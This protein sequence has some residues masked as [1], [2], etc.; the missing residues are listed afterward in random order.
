M[1]PPGHQGAMGESRAGKQQDQVCF[2][3]IFLALPLEGEGSEEPGA[4]GGDWDS[5]SERRRGAQAG[6][7][8]ARAGI[9]WM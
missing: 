6:G 1:F 7:G 4:L 8:L 3:Q 2:R 5:G 9:A